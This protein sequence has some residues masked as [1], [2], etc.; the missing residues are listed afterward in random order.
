MKKKLTSNQMWA[1]EVLN[2]YD[3]MIMHDGW[4]TGGHGTKI[5]LNTARALEKMGIVER[6]LLTK[7]G[8]EIAQSFKS[9]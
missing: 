1:I 9:A 2:K 7:F 3:C 5:N 4:V 6:G 8:K